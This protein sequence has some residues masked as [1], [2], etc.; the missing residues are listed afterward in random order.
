MDLI[1]KVGQGFL[2][3]FDLGLLDEQK[4]GQGSEQWRQLALVR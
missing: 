1:L 4:D 2:T 3:V